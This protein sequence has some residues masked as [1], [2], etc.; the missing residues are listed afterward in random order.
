MPSIGFCVN[1]ARAAVLQVKT[2]RLLIPPSLI[3]MPI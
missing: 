1:D 2:L 3:A